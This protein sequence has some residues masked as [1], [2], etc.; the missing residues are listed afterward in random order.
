[1]HNNKII[2]LVPNIAIDHDWRKDYVN[3][4][5]DCSAD[6]TPSLKM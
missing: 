5:S 1:M 3:S 4:V 6:E 2:M